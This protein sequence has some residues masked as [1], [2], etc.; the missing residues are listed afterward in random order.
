M[1]K[2]TDHTVLVNDVIKV[3]PQTS[4]GLLGDIQF[5]H[6]VLLCTLVHLARGKCKA[7][8]IGQ[9]HQK[10]THMCQDQ[11]LAPMGEVEVI[12]VLD[13]LESNSVVNI[14]KSKAAPRF[15][16]VSLRMDTSEVVSAMAI[17]DQAQLAS[18]L[19]QAV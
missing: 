16:K 5:Q 1:E 10:Y 6:K 3:L 17:G 14:K 13:L 7:P 4:R 8:T 9:L 18:I 15:S 2:S 12:H 19:E 11:K